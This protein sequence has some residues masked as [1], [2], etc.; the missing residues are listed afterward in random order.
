MAFFRDGQEVESG[1]VRRDPARVRGRRDDPR[2]G[3]EAWCASAD[4]A[5]GDRQRGAAGAKEAQT[6]AAGARSAEGGYRWDAGS[7][8]PGAAKTAAHGAS[9]LDAA[10][11]GAS[12]S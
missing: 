9:H 10:A 7:R 3:E 5:P 8:P 12:R 1:T 11:G 4:G 6:P 2:T